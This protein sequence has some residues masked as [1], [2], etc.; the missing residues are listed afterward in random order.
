M[1]SVAW[2][3]LERGWDSP[4][5]FD[6]F[7]VKTLV[8]TMK[9]RT[10]FIRPLCLPNLLSDFVNRDLFA[11][12]AHALELNSSVH[13]SEQSVVHALTDIGAGMD[14]SSALSDKDVA[15][16]NKLTIGSLDAKTL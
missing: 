10:E 13:L 9:K 15:G 16:Q 12:L 2:G 11:V 3:E 14:L 8:F 4:L 6:R 1:K 7:I 5:E